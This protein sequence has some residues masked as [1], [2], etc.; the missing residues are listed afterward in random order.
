MRRPW[1]QKPQ[2]APT[3]CLGET[4]TLS[5][6]HM[7]ILHYVDA[8]SVTPRPL[9]GFSQVV[10]PALSFWVPGPSFEGFVFFGLSFQSFAHP[11]LPIHNL[12]KAILLISNYPPVDLQPASLPQFSPSNL[13]KPFKPCQALPNLSNSSKTLGQFEIFPHMSKPVQTV[14][15]P[16]KLCQTFPNHFK[17]FPNHSHTF[18]N[19]STPYQPI[20]K[21]GPSMLG[22][23]FAG[24]GDAVRGLHGDGAHGD[25]G[26]AACTAQ[27]HGAAVHPT[28]LVFFARKPPCTQLG[29]PAIGALLPFLFWGRVSY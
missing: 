3:E 2:G 18:P 14:L 10:V 5:G 1:G 24:R 8:H 26:P 27:V 19:F 15:I 23:P 11:N 22:L 13:S 17:A 29:P 25:G 9:I 20:P 6:S 16:S 12:S 4:S 28:S 7:D 21:T